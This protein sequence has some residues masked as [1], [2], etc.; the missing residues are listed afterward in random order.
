MFCRDS[1]AGAMSVDRRGGVAKT[2]SE[3]KRYS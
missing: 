3:A 1:K 2:V